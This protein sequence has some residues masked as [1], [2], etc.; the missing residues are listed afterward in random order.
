MVLKKEPFRLYDVEQTKK[1]DVVSLKLNPKQ[2]EQLE[3]C[4]KFLN[5]DRDGTTIKALMDSGRKVLLDPKIKP[6]FKIFLRIQSK[7][8]D[9]DL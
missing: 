3:E 6:F 9:L 1:Q 4:K 2:R 7:G 5:M 8:E